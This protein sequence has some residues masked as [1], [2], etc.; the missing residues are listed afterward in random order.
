M[1]VFFVVGVFLV[2]GVSV[3][4]AELSLTNGDNATTTP[5]VATSITGFQIVGPGDTTT[6]VKL[7][8][9]NGT[10]SMTTTDGLTFTGSETGSVIYFS[11]TVEDINNALS[12]L[13]YTRASTGTDSLEVSLVNPG[14][15]FFTDNNHLYK[16]ISGSYSWSAAESAAEAQ[17]AYGA[18]GYLATVTSAAENTFISNRLIGDGWIGAS[19]SESEGIWKWMTGPEAGTVFW[20]GTGGG[21]TVGGNYANWNTGE[22]NQSGEEDCAQ[23]YVASGRW[24]DLGCS[25]SL[26]YVVEFGEDGNMPTVVA[27]NI[28]IVTADVPALT[29]L[30]PANGTIGVQPDATLDIEFSKNVINQ[31]GSILIKKVSDDSVVDT[32]DVASD[33]VSGSGTDT[34][35]ITPSLL[36]EGEEVYVIIPDTVFK[37]E[38]G[39]YFDGVTDTTTW[40]FTVADITPASFSSVSADTSTSTEAVITWN[41]NEET[42]SKVVYGLT[43]SYSTSTPEVDTSPLV[44]SHTVALSNLL[45]CTTY[46]YAVVGSDAGGNNATSTDDT[47]TTTGC[48]SDTPS[49]TGT[50]T[51]ITS[52]SGGTVGVSE[53]GKE[54]SVTAPENTTATSSSFVIQIQA[55]LNTGVI[56]TIGRPSGVNEIGTTFFDV[57]AIINGDTILDSFDEEVIV[58]YEYTD[59]EVMNYDESSLWLYHYT[60]GGWVALNNC[61]LDTNANTISC[62]TP[63]FSIFGLFGSEEQTRSI[64]GGGMYY[65]CKDPQASNYEYFSSHKQE[66]CVY[67]NT[68]QKVIAVAEKREILEKYRDVFMMLYQNGIALP[69]EV[70]SMLAISSDFSSGRDLYKGL[71]GEDVRKLQDILIQENKGK[72]ARELAR[73]G[74]TG[75]FGRYTLDALAEYQQYSG[76]VPAAGYFGSIT[77]AYMLDAGIEM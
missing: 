63:G 24:N 43:S 72:F 38:I 26:G 59:D 13:K 36:P 77:R 32:I 67:E 53:S 14:E 3:A 9:T 30:S 16:F 18:T 58:E 29:S 23:T 56:G 57:K 40:R 46:H 49:I 45:S 66:L 37:D 25:S 27:T 64:A 34:I 62:T 74:A 50:S 4:Y 5:G 6:P 31:T 48:L 10:L 60:N 44:L 55:I 51:T 8:T 15:V 33:Q 21:S 12:T 47:F 76:I 65:G 20:Q 11:G 69:D 17:E 1:L 28:S 42:S 70:V 54:F 22:P 19:D 39:N 68:T 61:V 73:V 71:E 7:F 41:T 75:Y 2:H 35:E 52:N